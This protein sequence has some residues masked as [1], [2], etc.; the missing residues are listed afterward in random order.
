ME[1][2][3]QSPLEL[4]LSYYLKLVQVFGLPGS[5]RT[6]YCSSSFEETE[7]M[8]TIGLNGET[9]GLGP[10]QVTSQARRLLLFCLDHGG[11]PRGTTTDGAKSIFHMAVTAPV[12]DLGLVERLLH[13]GVNVNIAGIGYCHCID[14]HT[15]LTRRSQQHTHPGHYQ[16]W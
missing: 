12:L 7:L 5:C 6:S 8:D 3:S 11:D 9:T 16:P 14:I 1:S 2:A 13:I 15:T 10:C 4:I